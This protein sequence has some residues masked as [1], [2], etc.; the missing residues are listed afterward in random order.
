VIKHPTSEWVTPGHPLFEVVREDVLERVHEDLAKGSV[1]YDLHRKDPYRL[2]VFSASIRDGRGNTLH[3]HLFVVETDMNGATSVKQPTIFL[4][5]DLAP[6]GVSIPEDGPILSIET[7][8]KTLVEQALTPL[9]MKV[10]EER[11]RETNT[12]AEH[13]EISLRELIHRQNLRLMDIVQQKERGDSTPLLAANLKQTEDRI[14]ELNERLERRGNELQQERQCTIGDIQH[15]GRAW[16]L[17]HPERTKPGIAPMVRDDEIER[18]A[19]EE[20]T[21]YEEARGWKVESVE[22]ENRG[23]DLISRKPHTEDSDTFVEV[24]FIEVKGRASVGEVALSSNE[25]KTAQRLKNDF[26]LYVVFNCASDPDLH[27]IQDPAQLGW[28]PL[29]VVEHYHLGAD[30]II[31]A[32]NG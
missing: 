11:Q 17:P 16:V 3:K 31:G 22:S 2:D 15:I 6:K 10:S 24:R 18:I 13:L 32:E 19:V 23:F 14:D 27:I 30:K 28:K 12:I 9:L 4:D 29:V 25:Y 8:E 20:A 1:F 7:I 5:L 26:W 21:K